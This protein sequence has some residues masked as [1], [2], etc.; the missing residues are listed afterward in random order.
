M[1]CPRGILNNPYTAFIISHLWVVGP[2]LTYGALYRAI[3]MIPT[4]LWVSYDMI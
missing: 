3:S 1:E 2:D 4:S